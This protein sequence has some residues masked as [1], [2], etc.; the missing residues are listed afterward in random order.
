MK[1]HDSG[2]Y[3]L[4]GIPLIALVLWL[5]APSVSL[6]IS[7]WYDALSL[8]GKA[9]GIIGMMLFAESMILS[10]R[11]PIF[12]KFFYGL[13]KVYE[14]HSQVGQIGFMFMLFHPLFLAFTYTDMSF[15]RVLSFLAPNQYT[16]PINFG[17]FA[18]YLLI[19]LIALTLYLRPKYHIWKYTHKWMGLAFFFAGLHV[20]LI[21]SDTSSF[22]PLRLYVLFISAVAMYAFIYHTIFGA[23]T[24]RKFRYRVSAVREMGEGITEITLTKEGEGMH[25]TPGQFA[26][27]SFRDKNIGYES[28]PFS[29]SGSVDSPDIKF[30][31]KN[32]GD[33]TAN[34]SKLP[35]GTT[36]FIEGPFGKF[37]AKEGLYKRQIWIAGGI[38]ITPFLSMAKSLT[39]DDGYKIDLYYCVKN[40]KE[41][42][43]LSLLESIQNPA[44]RIIPHYSDTA[45]YMNADIIKATSGDL[46]VCSVFI[47]APV[48]MIRSLRKQLSLSGV[49]AEN[50]HSEEF[51]LQ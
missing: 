18:L 51:G 48:P 39:L 22:L 7:S 46:S 5:W 41:A 31:V 44:L 37:S 27:V 25:F 34:L 3:F 14:K 49:K 43:Y 19:I 17:Q 13:N 45:G 12:E 6:S 8:L 33:F 28:H 9:T 35:V 40:P 47:C 36:A 38:G 29:L 2:M 10:A 16:W 23:Y 4:F 21:P 50:L 30:T 42:V 24:T 26:F 1:K 20:F 32:L 15:A 11:L